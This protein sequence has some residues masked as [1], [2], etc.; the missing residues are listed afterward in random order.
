VLTLGSGAARVGFGVTSI[1]IAGE[2]VY[3]AQ[4]ERGLWAIDAH[5]GETRTVRTEHAVKPRWLHRVDDDGLA[6]QDATGRIGIITVS[7]GKVRYLPG[8]PYELPFG[9]GTAVLARTQESLVVID[10]ATG[11]AEQLPID[12]RHATD[13]ALVGDDRVAVGQDEFVTIYDRQS[14]KVRTRMPF[15][16]YIELSPSPD[17]TLLVASADLDLVPALGGRATFGTHQ[18]DGVVWHSDSGRFAG[19]VHLE[20]YAGVAT[21]APDSSGFYT[22]DRKGT[23]A[24]RDRYG[25]PSWTMDTALGDTRL[26]AI[27]ADGKVAVGGMSGGVRVADP[28]T[29]SMSDIG[30]GHIGH[31]FDLQFTGDSLI[32]SGRDG[33]LRIWD[34]TSGAQRKVLSGSGRYY[35]TATAEGNVAV[36]ERGTQLTTAGQTIGAFAH[37]DL[38]SASGTLLA[39]RPLS[40]HDTQQ[41]FDRRDDRSEDIPQLNATLRA[42][43]DA[44]SQR[45]TWLPIPRGPHDFENLYAILPRSTS[46][47]GFLAVAPQV[48]AGCVDLAGANSTATFVVTEDIDYSLRLWRREGQLLSSIRLQGS[49]KDGVVSAKGDLAVF[50]TTT[51][52][53]LWEPGRRVR[54]VRLGEAVTVALDASEQ[55]LAVG[56]ENGRIGVW[57]L[58]DLPVGDEMP[59]IAAGRQNSDDCPDEISRVWL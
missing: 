7:T 24:W 11:V 32:S 43:F 38:W 41:Y 52:L 49:A 54:S 10:L 40:E 59:M 6:F 46:E 39:R 26:I 31:T 27:A 4:W 44:T 47:L 18:H 17:G 13:V 34:L 56:F 21:W 23:L 55:R 37:V 28:T 58:A 53:I 22:A 20:G 36:L 16:G 2:T 5:S 15:D 3:A 8:G 35:W 1:A 14:G 12:G 45:I 42:S 25:L 51:G 19:W 33:T 29:K 57:R 9:A 50:P 30:P 48:R